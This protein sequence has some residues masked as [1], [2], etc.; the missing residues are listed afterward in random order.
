MLFSYNKNQF[1]F[2]FIYITEQHLRASYQLFFSTCGTREYP[3][4]IL[5]HLFL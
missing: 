4:T 2:N 1:P 3:N 5:N